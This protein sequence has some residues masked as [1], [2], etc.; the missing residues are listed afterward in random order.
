MLQ[1]LRQFHTRQLSAAQSRAGADFALRAVF[2]IPLF[3][4]LESWR[5]FADISLYLY[6]CVDCNLKD[7]SFK[8]YG[9]I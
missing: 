9:P 2:L 4:G 3:P 1:T 5:C 8:Y 7:D 6:L